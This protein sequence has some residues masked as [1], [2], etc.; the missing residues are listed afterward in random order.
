LESFKGDHPKE[1]QMIT[2][3]VSRWPAIYPL[4]PSK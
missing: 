1:A 3:F 4:L 2:A